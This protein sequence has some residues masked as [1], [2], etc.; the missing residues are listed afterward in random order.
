MN[1]V[2]REFDEVCKALRDPNHALQ[3]AW[4][5]QEWVNHTSQLAKIVFKKA[6]LFEAV[7]ATT[8]QQVRSA[9]KPRKTYG[10]GEEQPG[11][12]DSINGDAVN[13]GILQKMKG[14]S[15]FSKIHSPLRLELTLTTD[16][17]VAWM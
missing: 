17:A 7:D 14:K 12:F 5:F 16:R 9:H 1:W 10:T 3:N 4:N 15:W 11:L 2:A 13:S 8:I 6:H